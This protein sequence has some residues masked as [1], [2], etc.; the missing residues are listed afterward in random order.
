MCTLCRCLVVVASGVSQSK[1]PIETVTTYLDTRYIGISKD[2]SDGP[3][4]TRSDLKTATTTT[5]SEP[6]YTHVECV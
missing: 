4:N 6:D 5:L 2:M 1:A 3:R